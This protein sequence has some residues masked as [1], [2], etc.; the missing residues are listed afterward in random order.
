MKKVIEAIK[1]KY[2]MSSSLVIYMDG[3]GHITRGYFSGEV[4]FEDISFN[5]L[6]ELET[7]LFNK[8][9]VQ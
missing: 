6:Q 8:E 9:N 5:S 2:G 3:S 7:I 4:D 1:R